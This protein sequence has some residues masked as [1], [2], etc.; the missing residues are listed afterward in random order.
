M[1][2][3]RKSP[4]LLAAVAL[5]LFH[6]TSAIAQTA[7]PATGVIEGRVV[8]AATGEPLPGAMVTVAGTR[9]ETA[10]ERDGS[11]RLVAV[12]A[13]ARQLVVTYLGRKTATVDAQVE[14][15]IARRVDVTL[16][17]SYEETVT[18]STT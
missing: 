8:D 1:R 14:A 2:M 18:V 9:I 15:G 7:S 17:P 13:G 11:F 10:T 12:P 6:I 5:S 4:T 16:P 3:I